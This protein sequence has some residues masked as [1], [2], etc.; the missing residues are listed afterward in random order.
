M[1]WHLTQ[2]ISFRSAY[3]INTPCLRLHNENANQFPCVVGLS[4]VAARE[5]LRVCSSRARI[6]CSSTAVP[7]TLR[8]AAATR[9]SHDHRRQW[10]LET[11]LLLPSCI[12]SRGRETR[13]R[14]SSLSSLPRA[15]ACCLPASLFRLSPSFLSYTTTSWFAPIARNP[16]FFGRSDSRKAAYKPATQATGELFSTPDLRVETCLSV[17]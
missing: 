14:T 16:H 7:S 3:P 5:R 6:H 1:R 2:R 11:R 9:G 10:V 8:V 17:V 12:P 13:N 4:P 15:A